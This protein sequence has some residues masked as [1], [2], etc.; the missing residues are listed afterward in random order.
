MCIGP[1][2]WHRMKR[3]ILMYNFG[4]TVTVAA[5]HSDGGNGGG[6]TQ[7]LHIY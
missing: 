4:E 3:G 5:A 6:A 2:V 7:L 1:Y